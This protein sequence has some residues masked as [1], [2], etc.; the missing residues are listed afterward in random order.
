M[1]Y[2]LTYMATLEKLYSSV[3]ACNED[4]KEEAALNLDLAAGYFVG[5]LE[6]KEDGG[7]FDG[8]L[9]FMLAKRMCVHFGTCT[10]S[11]Q[12]RINERM[13]SL[14][15]ASHSEVEA[16]ACEALERTVTEIQHSMVVPLIQG[17]LV[18]AEENER[19]SDQNVG[20][21]FYPE[22]FALAQSILPIVDDVDHL[23]ALSIADEMVVGFPPNEVSTDF[24]KVHGAV[25]VALSKMDG[26]DCSEIG[27][28]GG[29][30]FCPG[31]SAGSHAPP[32]LSTLLVPLVVCGV[33]LFT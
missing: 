1:G 23:S 6:G 5:S 28:L 10:V 29:K 21:E 3:R 13:I 16:G 22:G 12:A 11:N 24:D 31:D 9:I 30:G 17:L 2:M 19:Y 18:S 27:S 25:Q 15:Y 7:T 26:V 14:L 4:E 32:H 8:D 33:L 20:A